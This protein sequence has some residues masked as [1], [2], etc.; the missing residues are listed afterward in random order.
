MPDTAGGGM[1]RQRSNCRLWFTKN[2]VV[3]MPPIATDS[4][5]FYWLVRSRDTRFIH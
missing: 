3:W 5:R 1:L 4:R 2:C